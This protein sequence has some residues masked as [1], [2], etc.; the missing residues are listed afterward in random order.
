VSLAAAGLGFLWSLVDAERRTWHD[1][2][3]GTVL[4]RLAP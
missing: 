2:A 4:V 1:L 3:S